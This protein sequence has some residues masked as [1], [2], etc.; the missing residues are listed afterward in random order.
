MTR[1]R[2]VLLGGRTFVT[3]SVLMTMSC[4]AKE[5]ETLRPT[6]PAVRTHNTQESPQASPE[7]EPVAAAEDD[8]EP[9]PAAEPVVIEAGARLGP[10]RMGM[11]EAE[12]R[13]LALP[14]SP[15]DSR[16]RRFGPYRIFFDERGVRRAEAQI[17]AL[18][19]IQLGT[20]VF[21]SGTHIHR[22][23][24]AFPAC[25]WTEGGGERYRCARGTLFVQTGHT[26]H[27]ERYLLAVE[28]SP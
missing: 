21:A 3:L 7:E 16:S 2:V 4:G 20:E 24:D 6:P 18:G 11:T 26:L 28:R 5:P 19:R 9:A 13:A 1:R 22:L 8:P 10:I 23:R 14:E 12:V 15:V 25:E 27:P 17:G